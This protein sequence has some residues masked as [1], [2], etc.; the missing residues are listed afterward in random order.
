MTGSTTSSDWSTFFVV[1][2]ID[3]SEKKRAVFLFVM[4]ASTLDN[5]V[6]G[7]N[8]GAIPKRLLAESALTYA[9]AVELA[10]VQTLQLRVCG[11]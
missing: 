5:T 1:N 2:G 11:S 9:K 3:N 4:G 10:R 7:I 6:Y 8:D